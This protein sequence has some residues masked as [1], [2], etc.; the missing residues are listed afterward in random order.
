MPIDSQLAVVELIVVALAI[1]CSWLFWV[2]VR[3]GESVSVTAHWG[4]LGGGTAGWRVT[5]ASVALLAAL[6][7]WPLAGALAV[8]DSRARRDDEATKTNHERED[9]KIALDEK[10]RAEERNDREAQRLR[11]SM[12]GKPAP[13]GSVVPA[14]TK[15]P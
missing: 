6:F 1:L 14:S 12:G 5:T 15:I 13:S 8:Y 9:A 10:H 2:R 11:E 7:L 3:G 4:G